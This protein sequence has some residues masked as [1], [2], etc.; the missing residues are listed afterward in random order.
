MRQELF[1][2]LVLAAVVMYNTAPA[3]DSVA[4]AVFDGHVHRLLDPSADTMYMLDFEGNPIPY[5]FQISLE[6]DQDLGAM[7]LGFRIWSPDG[8]TWQYET[9]PDGWGPDGPNTGLSAVTVIPGSRLDPPDS[10]FDMTGL[11]VTEKNV[12]GQADDTLVLGGVAMQKALP[13]GPMEPMIAI[14][15]I[16]AST[17][18]AEIKTF[19]IDSAFVPPAAPFVYTDEY[20]A[21]FPP[22]IAPAVCYPLMYMDPKSAGD[23]K[24]AAPFTFD[25]RQNYPNPFNPSTVVDYSLERKSRVNI[26]IFNILGQKVKTLVDEDL[27]AGVHRIVWDGRDDRGR[28]VASGIYFYKMWAGD[29]VET[30]KMALIR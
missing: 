11:L 1:T 3:A 15:F 17:N 18:Q 13:L 29:F 7:S 23:V 26:S 19:C 21:T 2:I 12:D 20:G 16:V 10:A 28:Q 25:L 24:S 30:R 22:G 27:E 8:A 5:Q 9:Q 6:N 14:H 4:V